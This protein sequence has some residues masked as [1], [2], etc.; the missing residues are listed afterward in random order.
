MSE[1]IKI[2]YLSSSSF[3]AKLDVDKEF[4]LIYEKFCQDQATLDNHLR[5]DGEFG[6]I[7]KNADKN[8]FSAVSVSNLR[9]SEIQ[10]VILKA[11]PEIIHFAGHSSAD[12]IFLEDA[13]GESVAV[14]KNAI[15]NFLSNLSKKPMIVFF[16]SCQSAGKL[17]RLSR[18]I[19]FVVGTQ[20]EVDDDVAVIFAAKF[21]EFL[22]L[23]ETVKAA[24]YFAKNY[25][26]IEGRK[27]DAKMYKLLVRNEDRS[28][29]IPKTIEEEEKIDPAGTEATTI[30]K[31]HTA[32]GI[33]VGN[34]NKLR[35]YFQPKEKKTVNLAMFWKQ[36]YDA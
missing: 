22:A 28:L 7:Y 29:P 17:K 32:Q 9:A 33:V 8:Y 19:D 15:V 12:E 23:G 11:A 2:L 5:N 27:D 26:E 16:N 3:Q 21:Y 30:I 35:Q 4:R 1:K 6:A 24:F 18:T 10:T 14:S 13:G 34:V 25:F 20:K 36:C 31:T